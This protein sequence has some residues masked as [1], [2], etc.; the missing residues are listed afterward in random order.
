MTGR[1]GFDF[2]FDVASDLFYTLQETTPDNPIGDRHLTA[3]LTGLIE[4]ATDPE[5]FG[6][7]LRSIR[8]GSGLS[9]SML[10]RAACM[11]QT[12][13]SEYERGL[14][15]PTLDGLRRLAE[16]FAQAEI[17]TKKFPKKKEKVP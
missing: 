15:L 11:S 9:Q 4:A 8:R 10:A 12:Q 14:H 1:D 6:E 5:N 17:D 13:I 16:G 3:Y 7:S 2:S